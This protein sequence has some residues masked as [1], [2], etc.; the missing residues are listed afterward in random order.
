MMSDQGPENN[1]SNCTCSD[2]GRGTSEEGESLKSSNG[3]PC[4][5]KG[6]QNIPHQYR[7]IAGVHSSNMSAARRAILYDTQLRA[8]TSRYT[9]RST[10]RVTKSSLPAVAG[11]EDAS[12]P[13][14]IGGSALS[15]NDTWDDDVTNTTMSGSYVIDPTDLWQ[16]EVHDLEV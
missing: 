15:V 5:N 14:G 12:W 11:A 7:Q 4:S 1:E 6:I 3:S 16:Y 2:S 13:S 9:D 8:T 10:P